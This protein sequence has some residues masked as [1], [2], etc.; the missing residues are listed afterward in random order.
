MTLALVYDT[1]PSHFAIKLASRCNK[2]LTLSSLSVNLQVKTFFEII[3]CKKRNDP[4]RAATTQNSLEQ[5]KTIRN[6]LERPRN[7]LKKAKQS[8]TSFVCNQSLL[9]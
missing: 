5:G 3:A 4:E 7:N 1:Q 2:L 9:H 6:E 8:K